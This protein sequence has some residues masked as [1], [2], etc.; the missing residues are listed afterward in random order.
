MYCEPADV[1]N[2][3]WLLF[4]SFLRI[5]TIFNCGIPADKRYPVRSPESSENWN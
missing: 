5:S 4:W 1:D 2:L 3:S